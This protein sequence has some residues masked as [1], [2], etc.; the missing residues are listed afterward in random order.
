MPSNS[1]TLWLSMQEIVM[2]F[3]EDM[4]KKLETGSAQYPQWIKE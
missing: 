3:S 4:A 2:F 1:L